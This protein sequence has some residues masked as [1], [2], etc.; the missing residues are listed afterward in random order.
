MGGSRGW[1]QEQGTPVHELDLIYLD[2]SPT[3]R[4]HTQRRRGG[5]TPL[6]SYGEAHGKSTVRSTNT[7][8]EIKTEKKLK[9]NHRRVR[10]RVT[11][12]DYRQMKV[13]LNVY[14]SKRKFKQPSGRRRCTKTAGGN[15]LWETI[16]IIKFALCNEYGLGLASSSAHWH[17]LTPLKN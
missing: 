1:T 8:T 4:Q 6:K 5:Q 2:S 3:G 16:R 7:D 12:A 17:G 13:R 14:S 9:T 10:D 15:R 11:T